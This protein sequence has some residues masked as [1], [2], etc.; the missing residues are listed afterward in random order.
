MKI[1]AIRMKE[2]LRTLRTTNNGYKYAIVKFDENGITI[3]AM[4]EA[5][6]VCSIVRVNSSAFIDYVNFDDIIK[7]N[8]ETLYNMVSSIKNYTIITISHKLDILN[9]VF[10]ASL[11]Y[12]YK[13]ANV[14]KTFEI[15]YA[16]EKLITYVNKHIT[17]TK[18]KETTNNVTLPSGFIN[19]AVSEI[20]N[21]KP[22]SIGDD[23]IVNVEL[24]DNKFQFAYYDINSYENSVS[25]PIT[26]FNE[27]VD[28]IENF[29]AFSKS[30]SEP[31]Q[32]CLTRINYKYLI[33]YKQ[34]LKCATSNIHIGIANNSLLILRYNLFDSSI[35]IT[36]LIANIMTK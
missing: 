12:S 7:I 15:E 27:I 9:D 1:F 6:I 13:Y 29:S 32:L 17:K 30:N 21:A 4:D 19:T 23:Y 22:R 5:K 35:I 8:V 14:S 11:N 3:A 34:I 33:G 24:Y 18:T 10:L 20:K 2:I 31:K 25:Y 28:S 16:D 36:T 26:S